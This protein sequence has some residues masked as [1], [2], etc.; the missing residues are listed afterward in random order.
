MPTAMRIAPGIFQFHAATTPTPSSEMSQS[1]RGEEG[2]TYPIARR[3]TARMRRGQSF[4]SKRE[5]RRQSPPNA[6]PTSIPAATPLAS[7]SVA[8]QRVVGE[9]SAELGKCLV[10][11]WRE[12][13]H[14]ESF[15]SPFLHEAL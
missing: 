12:I 11:D 14:F 13:A 9:T 4:R 3:L 7:I 2:T 10:V 15:V 1:A 8:D 6:M 5:S